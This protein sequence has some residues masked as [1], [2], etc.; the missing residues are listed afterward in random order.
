MTEP[1]ITYDAQL[2]IN[3]EC[4]AAAPG[5][6][7]EIINTATGG[8]IGRVADADTN[9]VNR[10]VEAAQRAFDEGNWSKAPIHERAR[11]LSRF[12]DLFEADLEAFFTLETL[13]N[14]RPIAETRAQISRLPQFYRYFAAVTLTRRSEVIPVEGSYL[15]YTQRVPLGVVALM[16]SFNHPL[17]ILSKS[18]APALA[19]GNS[20]VIKPSE[21]TP[22]TTVRLVELLDRAGIPKGVVNLVNGAGAVAGAALASHP[23]IRKVVFTGSTEVGRAIGEAAA[24][25]FAATT[26]ELGGKGAVLI[27]EDIELERAVN[28]A[29]FAAFIAAGQTCVCG[30]RILFQSSIFPAFFVKI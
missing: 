16:T 13:N 24:R 27:F 12:A 3:G 2:F 18:L 1:P 5:K 23:K 11:V 26:L 8:A 25:N 6:T 9:D 29:A 22:L 19:T 7:L 21:Q 20:V 15:C 14:G 10:A 30:S 28:G 4:A 17:M